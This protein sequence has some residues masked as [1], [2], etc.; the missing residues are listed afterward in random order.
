M[1]IFPDFFLWRPD[2]GG[3]LGY[4]LMDAASVLPCLALNVQ[5]GHNV[6]DL[7]AAPG[8]KTL[9]LLQTY[10]IGKKTCPWISGY[11]WVSAC[12][13]HSSWNPRELSC[14]Q[15]FIFRFFVREWLLR[16]SNIAPEESPAQLRS[17]AAFNWW[18]NSYLHP[19]RH[20]MGWN[21][22]E[23]VWP[24]KPNYC[25]P[26]ETLKHFSQDRLT[27]S[28]VFR[29]WLTSPAPQTDT[30]CWRMTTTYSVKSGLVRDEDCRSSSSSCCSKF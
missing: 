8:G 23:H 21:W 24:S 7:C 16:V 20:Q 3:F 19:R 6:L 10:S 4:Y 29:S 28:S 22:A 11:P 27:S 30:R 5:E 18:E 15:T 12:F 13:R 2:R 1:F 17:Q 9:A 14:S 26:A 25:L